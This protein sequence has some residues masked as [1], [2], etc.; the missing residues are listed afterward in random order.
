MRLVTGTQGHLNDLFRA[1]PQFQRRPL[2]AQPT[3]MVRNC[4]AGQRRE[5]A[6]KM[7]ARKTRDP[8]QLL[9][10]Q[11]FVQVLLDMGQYPQNALLIVIPRCFMFW[12][13]TV[14]VYFKLANARTGGLTNFAVLQFEF[15]WNWPAAASVTLD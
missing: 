13:G 6:M 4:L 7:K 8:R 10:I 3:D 5:D 2:Q 14:H 9:Q 1:G 11:R 12:P 15:V